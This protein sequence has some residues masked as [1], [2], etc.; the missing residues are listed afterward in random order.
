MS[1]SSGLLN[2]VSKFKPAEVQFEAY[3]A[4]IYSKLIYGLL[5]WGKSSHGNKGMMEKTIKRAWKVASY[6]NLDICQGLLN[7]DS[8]FSSFVGIKFYKIKRLNCHPY[9]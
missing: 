9:L 5:F 2:R 3:Y 1:K 4:L 6:E 8:I 7:F